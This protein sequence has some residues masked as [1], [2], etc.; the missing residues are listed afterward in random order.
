MEL[1][2]RAYFCQNKDIG[3]FSVLMEI[4][5]EH[6]F[7][8]NELE[9]FLSSDQG[10]NEVKAELNRARELNVTGVPAFVINNKVAF[11]GAQEPNFIADFLS[12]IWNPLSSLYPESISI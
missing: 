10:T 2:F 3:D 9:S 1:L 6:G 7:D 4:G 8:H 5:V 12:R 11:S